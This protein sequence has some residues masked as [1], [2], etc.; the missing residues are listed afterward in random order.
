VRLFVAINL[1][2]A[3]RQDILRV[4]EP[5]RRLGLPVK[6]VDA[7][8]IHLTLKF[9]GEVSAPRVGELS[10][11]VARAAGRARAFTLPVGGFGAFPSEAHARVVWV[12]CE[13]VPALELLQHDV[14]REFA[15]LGFP[16]EG[17]PFRPH[18]T[19]GRANRQAR[20]GVPHLTEPLARLVY[21]G[22]VVVRSVELMESRLA[23]TGA[24]YTACHSAPLA[25]AP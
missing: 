7:T 9:L 3:M 16:L 1:P 12:G 8:G 5:L 17:R 19:L 4:V 23:P 13:A 24:H 25:E 15:A 22:E 14:E 18:L 21:H 10:A 20:G 2:D 6:W 11:A